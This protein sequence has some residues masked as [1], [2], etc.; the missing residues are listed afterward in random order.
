MLFNLAANR[1]AV[2][3][4]HDDVGN[5]NIRAILFEL[6]QSG[7]SVRASDHMDIFAAKRDLDD[8]AHGRAVVDEI[9]RRGALDGRLDGRRHGDVLLRSW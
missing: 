4:G 3:I 2:L 9:D 6:R 7:S 5:H 8:F 1:I